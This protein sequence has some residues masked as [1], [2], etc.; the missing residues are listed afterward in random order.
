M[1]RKNLITFLRTNEK[2]HLLTFQTSALIPKLTIQT[3]SVLCE[4][5]NSNKLKKFQHIVE[6]LLFSYCAVR[7]TLQKFRRRKREM[8]CEIRQSEFNWKMR[9]FSCPQQHDKR[10]FID[11]N[12]F[13]RWYQFVQRNCNGSIIKCNWK[14]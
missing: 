8:S 14:H 11:F 4:L 10:P 7:D 13:Y 6:F 9:R 1:Y 12:A 5:S 3:L 2:I